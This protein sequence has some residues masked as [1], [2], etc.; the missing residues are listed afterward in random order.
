M[1]ELQKFRDL[2][3]SETTLKAL[4]KKGFE[5]PTPIQEKVIPLLLSWKKDIVGQA[6][7]GTGKTAAFGIPLIERLKHEWHIQALILVPTRELAIQVAEEINSLQYEKK[8]SIISIYGWQSYDIQLRALKRGV[9]IIV[10]T[11]GRVIDHIN[12]RTLKLEKISYMILDEADEMLNMGFIDDIKEIFPHTNPEKKVLLFSATMPREILQVAKK[13]MRDY[14]LVEIKKPQLTTTQTDQ[15]Y[16]EVS[17]RDKFE[18]LCRIVDIESQFYWIVFCKTKVDVDFIASK[19][20]ERG[21]PAQALHGDIQQKQR[22]R[23]LWLF[24]KRATTILVA[25][26]VAARGIDVQDI[27]H[28]INYALPQDP[29]SYIHRVGRTGRAGKTGIAITFV[30]PDEYKK[31]VFFQRATKTNIKKWEIPKIGDIM[32][33]KKNKLKEQIRWALGG[34]VYKKYK[35]FAKEMLKEADA[36]DVVAAL[37]KMA[38]A[39]QLD[40]DM[41]HDIEKVTIDTTG[42]SRLFIALGRKQGY[43]PRTLVEFIT[44]ETEVNPRD[45]DEVRVMEEFSF[46]TVPFVEAEV[47]MQVFERKRESGKRSLVS[48]AK[49]SRSSWW[50]YRSWWWGWYRSSSTLRTTEA[51]EY[52]KRWSYETRGS[53]QRKTYEKRPYERRP[54]RSERSSYERPYSRE[55]S[56]YQTRR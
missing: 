47:I 48:K 33:N 30:T 51:R 29:E 3:I 13:Y 24:K 25:T 4:A 23:I 56:W 1:T 6:E 31:I 46:I 19:L 32:Q 26:D 20:I 14:D 44:K 22:E 45:I 37:L 9:D 16:F 21:Y 40:A 17:S 43:S 7:T 54:I 15:M 5:E 53:Y 50:T 11:P 28:I 34:E 52:A 2:W 18:A 35:E 39:D 10:G 36:E 42:K 41:Y 38:Y 8:L 49:E 55:R 12:R 27:S